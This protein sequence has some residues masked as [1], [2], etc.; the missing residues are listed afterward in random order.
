MSV[1]ERAAG[2]FSGLF[3]LIPDGS[4]MD[5]ATWTRRHRIMLVIATLHVPFLVGLGLLEGPEPISGATLPAIA[6]SELILWVGLVAALT[7]VAALPMLPRRARAGAIALAL[8]WASTVL[9]S[10]SGGF[11][12]AHFH[13][14]VAVVWLAM[15]E[16]WVPLAIGVAVV[17]ATHQLFSILEMGMMFNHEPAMQNHGFWANV[18]AVFVLAGVVGILQ[19]WSS[20]ESSRNDIE[21]KLT[22]IDQLEEQRAEIERAQAEIKAQKEEIDEVNN[23]LERKAADFSSVM[24]QAADGDLT[25]RMDTDTDAEAMEQIGVAFNDMMT[26]I[27][28]TMQDIQSFAEDV[29][30]ASEKTMSGVDTAEGLSKDVT[31]SIAEIADGADEQREMLEQVSDEMNNLSATIEE[32]ASSTETVADAAQQTALIADDGEETAG[33]AIDSVQESQAAIDATATKVQVL[34]ERMT[35]IGEIVDLI[36]D[37]AEQTNLLALNANI[38][39]ARASGG[40]GAGGTDGFAVVADEVKQ[41]AEET[42]DAAQDIEKLIAGT[43]AQTEETVA[44]VRGAEEHMEASAEAVRDAA[45]AFSRVAGNAA[46]TDDGIREISQATDDQAASTEETVS[47]AE[48][49][50]GISRST[51]VEADEVAAAADEQL[52]AMSQ[53]TDQAGSLADQAERLQTLLRKFDVSEGTDDGRSA[54]ATARNVA[55][56]DGGQPN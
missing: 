1:N 10:F 17:A 5:A 12:E 45:D 3:K 49:V 56:G 23:E 24:T 33:T 42:Q 36:S 9:V 18:H 55:V 40:S 46:E 31:A 21:E 29:S 37:I 53:A 20:I 25:M 28:S 4:K 32:V 51:A 2:R 34:D 16:D 8:T 27:E 35:D 50:A 39:A 43:Q 22:E 26:D 30:S 6:T 15:Y 47:M 11:I 19:L 44:E 38:E 7:A 13:Y 41:L 48:E 52:T 54:T 14:F